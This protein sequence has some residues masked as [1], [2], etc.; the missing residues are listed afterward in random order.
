M[1]FNC[2]TLKGYLIIE[3]FVNELD[4]KY[5]IVSNI[6]FPDAFLDYYY[7]Q[8]KSTTDDKEVCFVLVDLFRQ[9]ALQDS[10]T[11]HPA[12]APINIA[13]IT[14]EEIREYESKFKIDVIKNNNNYS[15]TKS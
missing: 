5:K 10:S 4:E 1:I 14:K 13:I 15:I 7:E 12:I 2:D 9:I 6:E 11:N 3:S 8:I